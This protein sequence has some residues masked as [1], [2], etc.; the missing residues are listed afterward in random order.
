GDEPV[1]PPTREDIERA[2]EADQ[3]ARYHRRSHATAS[4]V[5]LVLC[6]DDVTR[7]DALASELREHGLDVMLLSPEHSQVRWPRL[8]RF[9]PHGLLV[10]ERSLS[11]GGRQ[12]VSAFRRDPFLKY[13]PLVVVPF[14]RIYRETEARANLAPV[15]PLL[16]PLG[17]EELG[18]LEQLAK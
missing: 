5:R 10:D 6:D 13:V 7:A 12:I 18:L 4:A 3:R 17:R 16:S 11:K 8:R 2:A 1:R 15:F 14:Q 9:A